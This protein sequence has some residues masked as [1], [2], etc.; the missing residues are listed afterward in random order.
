VSRDYSLD[1]IGK[2]LSGE[3]LTPEEQILAAD[4][5]ERVAWVMNRT[6]RTIPNVIVD[7]GASDGA[8]ARLWLARGD[9]V[10]AIERHPA[11]VLSLALSG[12]VCYFGAAVDGLTAF[13]ACGVYCYDV[14]IAEV[15]EHLNADDGAVIL[16]AIPEHSDYGWPRLVVTVP[17]RQS[18]SFDSSGRSRWIWPDHRRYFTATSL[19]DWLATCGWIVDGSVTPIVGTLEDSIWLGAVCRRV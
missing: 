4:D 2:R 16:A 10:L 11:H 3:G 1:E 7:V 9:Q 18:A 14:V 17:N 15:L 12:A 19:T 5:R 8:L 13:G 6:R